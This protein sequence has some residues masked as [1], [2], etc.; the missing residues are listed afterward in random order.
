[1]KFCTTPKP[2]S[3]IRIMTQQNIK[4]AVDAVVFGY[5]HARVHVLLIKQRFGQAKGQWALPGGFVKDDEGLSEAVHREL[6][7]ETGIKINYLEQLYTF[8]DQLERDPRARVVSVSYYALVNSER[9]SLQASTDAQEAQWFDIY[10]LPD[11]AY[12]HDAILAC[13]LERLRSKVKYQPI[14]FNLLSATFP[15]SDLENLYTAILDR[16]IDR[17]NFR[18]KMLSFGMLEE[19]AELLKT[20]SGRPAKLFRFNQPKYQALM[21]EGFHFEIKF[22]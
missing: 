9:F 14:G 18:K 21:E 15:F 6:T 2:S 13:A 7:E 17:R 3:Y 4:L 1:M 19:T 10:D 20:G 8:G 5:Q 11:L 12:D 22:A 16:E